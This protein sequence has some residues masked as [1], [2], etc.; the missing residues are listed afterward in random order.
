MKFPRVFLKSKEEN[1]I[2][3]G[4]PW[5]F[6]NEVA[7]VKYTKD[8]KN[9]QFQLQDE[10]AS[11][12]VKNGMPVELYSKGGLFL[13]TGIINLKSKI[14]VRLLGKCRPEDIFGNDAN[15][16]N[17]ETLHTD[18]SQKF[19]L[20]RLQDA[21]DARF[22]FFNKSDSYRLVFG[23]A[24]FIP[25][26]IV[27]RYFDKDGRVFLSVQFLSLASEI[28]RKE[29]ISAM[30]T[31]YHP[32]GIYERSDVSVR[33]LEGLEQ[34]KGWIGAEH[35][36]VIIIKENGVLLSV[37]LE[38]GQKTG[39][40]LDQ[41]NNRKIVASLAKGKRVLDTFTHTGA[42]G[43]N[44]FIGGAS[45]VISVDISPEAI[46]TVETNIGFNKANHVMKAVC[47]DVFDLLR[48]YEES[49][50][51]FDMIILDPPAFAKSSSKVDKAYGG[52]KEINLRA[53]KLLEPGGILVSC[54]CSHF[55]DSIRFYDMLMHAASDAKR[56]IQIF[57]KLGA[58][59]DH[60][61][62]SGYSK[63]EYLK[64]AIMRVM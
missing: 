4:S 50:E 38:N 39:Y 33:E 52:Y 46:A 24:D 42:F 61:I 25:G 23:E 2:K 22:I 27:D 7:F 26:F 9:L 29:L 18:F 28:F 35:N 30:Q 3:Q 57:H 36:P 60:P 53:M 62:L 54:S 51:K 59:P 8:G 20:N 5:V 64:C 63:S 49:G 56:S 34:K 21:L 31:L 12:C 17:F 40:F 37:D 11:S 14:V 10:L 32:F 45:K 19:F 6:D 58:G 44:A 16:E 41:K 48:E 13:G 43:L 47:A 55:F 1:D 15:A